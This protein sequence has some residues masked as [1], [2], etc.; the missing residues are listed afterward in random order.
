MLVKLKDEDLR[1]QSAAELDNLRNTDWVRS[2]LGKGERELV[3]GF[4]KVLWVGLG[5]NILHRE[6]LPLKKNG[7][8][9]SPL[10]AVGAPDVNFTLDN[11]IYFL[12]TLI[13]NPRFSLQTHLQE[14]VRLG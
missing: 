13:C 11:N 3:L 2:R 12:K 14:R 4:Y 6:L 5:I 8:E 7:G 9:S 10:G 1:D